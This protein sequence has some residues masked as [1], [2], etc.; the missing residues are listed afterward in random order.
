MAS[1][2]GKLA[3]IASSNKQYHINLFDAQDGKAG[4][5]KSFGWQSDNHGGHMSRP[6]I[7][8]ET[9][10]VRPRAFELKTGTQLS[11]RMPG[12][13]CGTYAATSD[14]LFFRSGNVTVWDRQ[15]GQTTKWNRL[16]P[17]CWLST[18]PASGLLL[19]PEGGG[20]C[21]CGSWLETSLGF[22]PKGPTPR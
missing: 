21:S 5:H 15:R 22:I 10:Y 14:A 7:V 12:G 1:S 19:S 11:V 9:I 20:G 6:A 4:W 8:G 17:D 13:G 2:K 16:R 3:L 18:I